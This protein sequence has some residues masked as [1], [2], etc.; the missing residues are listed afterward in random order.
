L[1]NARQLLHKQ[2]IDPLWQGAVNAGGYAPENDKAR[3]LITQTARG[4]S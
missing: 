2:M 4:A 1:R 3:M